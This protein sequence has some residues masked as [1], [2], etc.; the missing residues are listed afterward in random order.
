MSD[1]EDSL[2]LA[3]ELKAEIERLRRERDEAGFDNLQ[4]ERAENQRLREAIRKHR[5][6]DCES[7]EEIN[8]ATKELWEVLDE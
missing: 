7:L 4:A 6:T 2:T 5:D 3:D 1:L 8:A